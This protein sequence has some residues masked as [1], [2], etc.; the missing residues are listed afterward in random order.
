MLNNSQSLITGPKM[1]MQPKY[2]FTDDFETATPKDGWTYV[3]V[4]NNTVSP[5]S[6]TR[7]WR[8]NSTNSVANLWFPPQDEVWFFCKFYLVGSWLFQLHPESGT[9]NS[10]AAGS[11]FSVA[12]W[13]GTQLRVTGGGFD[14]FPTAYIAGS[15]SYC[16]A[17]YKR[18]SGSNAICNLWVS[19]TTT[20]PATPLFT[21]TNATST[22]PALRW[23]TSAGGGT[24]NNQMD[25]FRLSSTE[26]G[27]DPI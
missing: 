11:V 20:R 18:G 7:S 15:V 2:F 12:Q 4:S 1:A 10:N 23:W 8:I 3:S 9:P 13:T 19:S 5:L 24:L 16:W 17:Q 27:S 26:I 25:N 14:V 21:R 6:G 22:V